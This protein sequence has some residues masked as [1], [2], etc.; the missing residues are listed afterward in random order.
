M[1]SLS[2]DQA[3]KTLNATFNHKSQTATLHTTMHSTMDMT[4]DVK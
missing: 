4:L 1:R 3:R 2:I